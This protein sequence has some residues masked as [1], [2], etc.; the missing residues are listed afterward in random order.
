MI[1]KMALEFLINMMYCEKK[2]TKNMLERKR[3]EQLN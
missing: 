3:I 1:F 2:G